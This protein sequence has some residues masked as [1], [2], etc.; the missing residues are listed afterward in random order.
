[1]VSRVLAD[2]KEARDRVNQDAGNSSR[3]VAPRWGQRFR[4]A[5]GWSR[6]GASLVL[7]LFLVGCAAAARDPDGPATRPRDVTF[8]LVGHG[9]HAGLAVRRTDIP[10]AW[11]PE[12][13]DFPDAQFLEVGWGDWDFYQAPDFRFWFM[14]KAGLWPTASVLTVTGLRGMP[15]EDYPCSDVIELKL[16]PPRFER[17]IGYIRQSFARGGSVRVP[18]LHGGEVHVGRFYPAVGSFHLFNTCNVWTARALR[19]AGYPLHLPFSILSFPL[20]EEANHFGRRIGPLSA[21]ASR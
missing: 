5:R 2:L 18:P 10:P 1:V 11:W 14:V 17:L 19:D 15:I 4:G 9:W 21:C 7:A 6:S 13:Q 3:A 8:Y 12:I 20:I 16:S